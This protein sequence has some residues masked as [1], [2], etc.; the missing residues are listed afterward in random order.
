[1]AFLSYLDVSVSAM[2]AQ[3]LRGEIIQQNVAFADVTRTENGGPYRRQMVVF[4]EKR[5]FKNMRPGRNPVVSRDFGSILEMTLA[6]RRQRKMGGVQVL[7]IVEDQTP[8]RPVF[9]PTHPD[10]D[11]EGFY[12][13]PNVD[14]PTE[15]ID[16][17]AAT[18]AYEANVEIFNEMKNMAAKA[19]TIGR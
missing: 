9:D 3:R 13:L 4:G 18:R 17:L 12:Y 1:M 14:V 10:A 8:L 11:E 19:L 6:E 16:M 5:P 15:Q 2:S 7:Q